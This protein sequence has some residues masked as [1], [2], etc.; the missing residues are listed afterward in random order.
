MCL[1]TKHVVLE[2]PTEQVIV[3]FLVLGEEPRGALEADRA[4]NVQLYHKV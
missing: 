4:I 1:K 3:V 2:L